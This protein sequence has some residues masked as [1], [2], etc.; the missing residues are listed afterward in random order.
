[1][2]PHHSFLSPNTM[3]NKNCTNFRLLIVEECRCSKCSCQIP[4]N[5][6]NDT[7]AKMLK[8]NNFY[9]I[10]NVCSQSEWLS[11]ARPIYTE[12]SPHCMG[13]V[14]SGLQDCVIVHQFFHHEFA[15]TDSNPM[16]R[17][18]RDPVNDTMRFVLCLPVQYSP[19]EVEPHP[20]KRSI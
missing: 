18:V 14:G 15:F 9:Q 5:S 4:Y 1:M 6:N 16:W 2:Q 20:L 7:S 17:W 19:P 8:Q 3:N 13:L 11:V 12:S 10:K